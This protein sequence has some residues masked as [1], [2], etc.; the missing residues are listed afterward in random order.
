MDPSI[1]GFSCYR[2][3]EKTSSELQRSALHNLFK[4]N[5]SLYKSR[6]ER[7]ETLIQT[8][9]EI[10]SSIMEEGN[11]RDKINA[12]DKEST[13]LLKNQV[14]GRPYM[15]STSTSEAYSFLNRPSNFNG[16]SLNMEILKRD[17]ENLERKAQEC[18]MTAELFANIYS[19][20]DF[21]K[22]PKEYIQQWRS[23][24]NSPTATE[25]KVLKRIDANNAPS[26]EG[27]RVKHLQKFPVNSSCTLM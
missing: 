26:I 4:N 5:K 9:N 20:E 11:A 18:R 19:N 12:G 15:V 14:E 6:A 21:K 13:L 3:P 16:N 8:V 7:I 22:D 17:I 27:F 2:P 10:V 25:R 1:Q 23:T 24:L